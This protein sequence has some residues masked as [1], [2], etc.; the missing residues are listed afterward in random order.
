M[1]SHSEVLKSIPDF[2]YEDIPY[3]RISLFRIPSFDFLTLIYGR[4]PQRYS[5]FVNILNSTGPVFSIDL[6]DKLDFEENPIN[7]YFR[8]HSYTI[9]EQENSGRQMKIWENGRSF[10]EGFCKHS[11]LVGDSI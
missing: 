1:Q 9:G 11:S 8:D 7:E 2:K 5:E 4:G 6:L 3:N 10:K